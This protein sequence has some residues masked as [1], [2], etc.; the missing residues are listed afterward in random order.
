MRKVWWKNGKELVEKN[1]LTGLVSRACITA[2]QRRKRKARSFIEVR[3]REREERAECLHGVRLVDEG[4][5]WAGN[6]TAPPAA[7]L[8]ELMGSYELSSSKFPPLFLRIN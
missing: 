6:T 5:K 4:G 1:L 3:E 8:N 7:G 2:R